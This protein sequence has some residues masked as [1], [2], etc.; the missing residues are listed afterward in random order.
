MK[1]QNPWLQIPA[2]DYENHM[3]APN[4]GQLQVLNKIFKEV[5]DEFNPKS[6]CVLGCTAG[7]GFE[8][9]INRNIKKIVGIDINQNYLDECNN[10]FGKYLSQMKLICA[11]LNEFELQ[12]NIFDLIYAALIFEYVD[13]KNLLRNISKWL[14]TDGILSM[15]F[16]LP[17]EK[18]N[19]VSDTPYHSLKS[20][21]SI[22]KLIDVNEIE[23]IIE[24][25]NFLC[26]KSY[27]INLPQ[28]KKFLVMYC[29]KVTG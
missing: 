28:D 13:F 20:L 22:M 23:D 10:R 27:N 25:E 17:S 12:S 21:S 24:R 29:K 18:S 15:V 19:P 8:H 9:L 26:T 2:D 7:N 6:I 4:V 5:L 16:Q 3:S 1:L 11:D 14:R